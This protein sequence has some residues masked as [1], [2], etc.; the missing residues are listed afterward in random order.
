MAARNFRSPR[1]RGEI[2]RIGWE[3][4]VLCFVEVKARTTRDVK[5]A[6]A[7]VDRDRQRELIAMAHEYLHHLRTKPPWRVDGTS[8]D[9]EEPA[10]AGDGIVQKRLPGGVKYGVCA[11]LSSNHGAAECLS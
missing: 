6:H 7:A 8:V 11:I 10:P 9:F 4:D 1:R 3:R 5:P 2:G